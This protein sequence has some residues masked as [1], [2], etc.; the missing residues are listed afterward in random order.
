MC[1]AGSPTGACPCCDEQRLER[2]QLSSRLQPPNRLLGS[3]MKMRYHLH[4]C[5]VG[6]SLVG[7]VEQREWAASE[8]NPYL[9]VEI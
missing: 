2:R 7:L 3:N 6:P 5:L 8:L 4:G 1:H 9:W